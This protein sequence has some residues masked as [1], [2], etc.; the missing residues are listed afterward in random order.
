MFRIGFTYTAK[1][2][3]FPSTLDTNM[4]VRHVV[5]KE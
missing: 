4:F 5:Q 3:D 1:L 2:Q